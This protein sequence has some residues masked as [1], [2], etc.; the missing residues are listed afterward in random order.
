[1]SFST[2]SLSPPLRRPT[3]ITMS[4]SVAPSR[5][6]RRVSKALTWVVVAPSGKPMTVHTFTGLPSSSCR[7]SD[8]Q[9]GFTHTDAKLNLRA[10]AHSFSKSG[11]TASGLSRV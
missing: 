8:T 9:P 1:M 4:T 11:F 2:Y 5:M 3:L 6:H 7:H 10:S